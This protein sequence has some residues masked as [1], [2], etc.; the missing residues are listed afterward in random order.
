MILLL[1]NYDSFT[2]N[3][4]QAIGQLYP[5]IEVVRNDEITLDQIREKNPSA[6]ILSPGPGYPKDAGI[7]IPVIQAFSGKIPLLGVCLGHQSIGQAFGGTIVRA[8]QLMHGKA[9][10][11]SIENKTPIFK[12]LP[13]TIPVARY[14]S[15]IVD[16]NT[17][18]TCLEAIAFD[19]E[20]QI[21]ALRHREH[22]TYGV[23]FHP[24]SILTDC[25]KT[26]LENFLTQVAKLPVISLPSGQSRIP[27][28]KRTA[29]K[30]YISR[31]I[32]RQ[33]LTEEEALDAMDCIMSGGATDSQISA[34]MI[35]LRMKG[36]TIPELTGFARAMRQ[37]AA[38]VP[39][40]THSVDI[41]GTGGDMAN[42]F[43]I[44]T[45]A[46]FVVAGAGLSVAKH[47]NRSVSSK[48]G[49]AD[50]LEALGVNIALTPDQA[51]Q[52]LHTCGLSFLF[53][54]KFHGSLRFA[55]T[56]R[57]ES[58]VRTVFN[59]LG[60]LCNPALAEF[61][62]LGVY[63]ETL[64]EPMALVLQNLGIRGAMIV[65]GNDGLDEITVCDTTKV[66]E[67]RENR[68]KRYELDPRN[69]GMELAKPDDLAGGTA[70]ENAAITL[71][72]LNGV[73]GPRRNIVVLNAA[74]ALYIG[75]Q[76]SS[77]EEGI[78]MA[79]ASIDQGAA[80]RKLE[81]LKT[82]TNEKRKQTSNKNRSFS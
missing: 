44:S 80:L 15:L 37:R 48:S 23:Q 78:R 74:C 70:E 6:I 2:Y 77:V 12:N 75:G 9:S 24:E 10:E 43:N 13:D 42:T 21:M 14:H 19:E 65:H 33:D 20:G 30:P 25:G 54:P 53:A 72:L 18:P 47:G 38:T 76:A 68:L 22:P 31:V 16:E 73:P 49:A 63:D 51:N 64:M 40:S 57:R 4:Y 28:E 81:E 32:D 66:L 56:A 61:I 41:V 67:I 71:E 62:L 35:A 11:I 34:F 45:T 3:L 79:Q 5:D 8:R 69:Y 82:F 55:A 17:V 52:C 36:E 60:P 27:P 1:D 7:T 46:S 39:E 50:V 58:G 29:L 59:L 26:I